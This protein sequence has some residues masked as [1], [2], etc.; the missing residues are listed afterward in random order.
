MFSYF[1]SNS[2]VL[3]VWGQLV[4]DVIVD[5]CGCPAEAVSL[6]FEDVDKRE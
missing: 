5:G 1:V 3:I 2:G 6:V 4:T